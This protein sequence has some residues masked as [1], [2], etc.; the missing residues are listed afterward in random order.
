MVGA[1]G[2]WIE[3]DDTRRPGIVLSI[4]QQQLDLQSFAGEKTE[5]CAPATKRGA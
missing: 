4:E 1:V 5:I 2:R 3:A